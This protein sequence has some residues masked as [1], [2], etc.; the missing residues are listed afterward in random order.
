MGGTRGLRTRLCLKCTEVTPHRTLYART[1]TE[2][3]RRWLQLFWACTR[4][5]S[6]NHVVLPT[7][8]LERASSPLPSTLAVAIVNALQE[9]PLDMNGLVLALRLRRV[10][11]ITHVFNS[12]VALA[13]GFLKGRSVVSEESKDYTAKTLEYLRAQSAESEHLG[14][15]PVESKRV[16]VSLYAQKQR[17]PGH[18]MRLVPAGVFCLVCGYRRI[19]L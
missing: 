12:E 1:T 3:R 13:V 10:L 7:Y 9:G 15:C 11:G 14:A 2:G 18:G 19:H 16:L 4:C 17:T 8:R 6:L 5:G